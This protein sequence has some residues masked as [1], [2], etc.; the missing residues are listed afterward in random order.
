MRQFNPEEACK[1]NACVISL[2]VLVLIQWQERG[3]PALLS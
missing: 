1:V 2:G 3:G